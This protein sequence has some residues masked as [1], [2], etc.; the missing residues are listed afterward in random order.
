MAL[1]GPILDRFRP[2]KAD[3]E[4]RERIARWVREALEL[5]DADVVKVSEIACNDPACPGLETVIL[6]MRPGQKTR[7]YKAKGS[8]VAQTRPQI[9]TAVREGG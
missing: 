6:V 2:P 4:S 8:A 1:L 7:A 5:G 3:P 9:V